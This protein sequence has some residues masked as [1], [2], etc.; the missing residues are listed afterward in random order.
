MTFPPWV[1]PRESVASIETFEPF[2][3]KNLGVEAQS[4]ARTNHTLSDASD[5]LQRRWIGTE[6]VDAPAAIGGTVNVIEDTKMTGPGERHPNSGPMKPK[7]HSR[8]RRLPA[9]LAGLIQ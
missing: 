6:E 7:E 4:I 9:N 3:H 1:S 2:F 5:L 8:G